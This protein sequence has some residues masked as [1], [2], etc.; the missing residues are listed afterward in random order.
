MSSSDPRTEVTLSERES[1]SE[2]EREVAADE[3]T[4]DQDAPAPTERE[5]DDRVDHEETRA[6]PMRR[7]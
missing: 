3:A 4:A 1:P 2:E 7:S 5:I 6:Y